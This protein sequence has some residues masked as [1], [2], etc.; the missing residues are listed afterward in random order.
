MLEKIIK[1]KYYLEHHHLSAPLLKERE[2]YI[3]GMYLRGLSR[4]TLLTA[5]DYLLRVTEFLNLRD[6][7]PTRKVSIKEIEAAGER[8]AN[9]VKNHPMKRKATMTS[10]GKFILTAVNWLGPLGRI[11]RYSSDDNIL[12]GLFSRCYHKCRYLTSPLL[13]E[14]IAYLQLWK[15]CGASRYMLHDIACYQIHVVEYLRLTSPRKVKESE[16]ARAAKE[17]EDT[18]N[19]GTRKKSGRKESGLAF[20]RVA[21][22][23][24]EWMGQ[25]VPEP[26]T[27]AQYGLVRQYLDHLVL[28]KGYSVRTAAGRDSMLKTFLMHLDGEGAEIGDVTPVI[29]DGYLERR[30]MDGCCRRTIA[31]TAS[32]LRDF[33]RYAE[34][35]K[36]CGPGIR[37]SIKSPRCYKMESLPS[38]ITWDQVRQVLDNH[39]DGSRRGVRD[40][41]IL[42][43]L[44]VYGLRSSEVADLRLGD[45]DWRRE[46]IHLRRAKGCR[47]QEMPLMK[48]VGESII[49]YLKEVR[50]NGSGCEHVFLC[51]RAPYRKMSTSSIYKVVRDELV[52]YDL[53]VKHRGPHTLRHSCATHLVNSGHSMKEVADLLGHQMLDTT[54][55]YA[56]VDLTGLRKV[57]DM[58]W[59]GVL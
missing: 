39:D 19:P 36:W 34:G 3:E 15:D 53:N 29:I 1:R 16:I 52:K 48:G 5:A 50:Q 21:T 38:F 14:R 28:E 54:R 51:L 7:E 27:P 55:I 59:E 57:A 40:R 31:G 46:I 42:E 9:T 11:E 2:S 32:V 18:A 33:F 35:R 24:L 10:K 12:S 45:I 37:A 43:L 47:P 20:T 6:D 13:E 58:S 44:S 8:W 49:R 56:K 26:D 30:G 25:Y 23:W 41:A 17:W 4:T 22:G